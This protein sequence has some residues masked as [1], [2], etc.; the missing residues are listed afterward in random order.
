MQEAESNPQCRRL[1]LK[2]LLIAE[3]QRLTKYPLLLESVAKVTEGGSPEQE[4]LLQARDQCRDVLSTSP[5]FSPF[6]PIFSHK[7]HF[8]HFPFFP[9]FPFFPHFPRGFPGAGEAA[10]SPGS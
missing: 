9:F 1:Q 5:V 7:P 2:D 8:S 6:S 4:K 3:M 10:P